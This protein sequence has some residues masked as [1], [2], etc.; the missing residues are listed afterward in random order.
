LTSLVFPSVAQDRDVILIGIISKP[1]TSTVAGFQHEL[2]FRHCAMS[3]FP[4][5]LPTDEPIRL[6]IPTGINPVYI[7][8]ADASSD[9]DVFEIRAKYH[10]RGH[11]SGA[12]PRNR[13]AQQITPHTFCVVAISE[14]FE[15]MDASKVPEMKLRAGFEL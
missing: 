4:S 12:H 3:V 1:I 9:S 8:R 11:I 15:G 10:T 2:T 6:L 13:S 7:E 14:K 5:P